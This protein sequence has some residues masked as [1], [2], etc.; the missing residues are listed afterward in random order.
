MIALN[1]EPES[2]GQ[3]PFFIVGSER[4]GTT[5]LMAILGHHSRL[6]VPEVTWYYPRFRAFLHT[7]GDLA[8]AEG[9]A[10]LCSEM[11]HGLKTPYFGLG[12]NPSTVV[13]EL[14][15]ELKAPSYREL[16]STILG[17]Y[18]REVGKP[19]WGEKTPH[20][21]YYVA[22][23]L[24]DFPT[25]RILHLNRD[26]RDVAVEQL[27]SAFG[28]TNIASA[29]KVW[30]QS[31]QGAET[32]R[33]LCPAHQWLEVRYEELVAE[34]EAS[35]QRVLNFLGESFEAEVL[36]F[37]Q[38]EIAQRRAL[39]RDHQQLG[40]PITNRSVGLY[41][42]HLSQWEQEVFAGIAGPELERAGYSST[43]EPLQLSAAELQLYEQ[44]DQRVR[45]ATLDAPEGHIVYE[46]RN[47]W[48]ADQRD[49]RRELGI[50]TAS[51][52]QPEFDW[53]AQFLSGQRAPLQWKRRF[54]IPRRYESE[55]LVL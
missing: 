15:S 51:A 23:I 20:N 54:G 33:A 22:E 17:R 12:W 3:A 37:H 9:L 5:L 41:H 21:L 6:A 2:S 11:V 29:A 47:D 19:R 14:L 25:A 50:W 48:L 52:E 35:I 49:L 40:E 36:N 39:T 34:P 28:P 10:S 44:W 26:G 53:Q 32:A 55:E 38:G 1:P 43:V 8:N 46:S 31:H 4:S 24:E 30:K 16:F 27:R 7:Y 42:R 18:A 45:A 13:A